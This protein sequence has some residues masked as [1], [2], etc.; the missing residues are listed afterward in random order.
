MVP[1]RPWTWELNADDSGKR[2]GQLQ[3]DLGDFWRPEE[4]F[5]QSLPMESAEKVQ[6][7]LRAIHQLF[8][9]LQADAKSLEK[10]LEK[11][12]P[13]RWHVA[14]DVSDMQKEIRRW[15]KLNQKLATELELV[16]SE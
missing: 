12:M 10:E 4:A 3:N 8:Q 15:R 16:P 14:N 6:S 1:G 2:L 11:G 7:Q 9:H 13:A 5:E